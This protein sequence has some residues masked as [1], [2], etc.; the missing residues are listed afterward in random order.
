MGKVIFSGVGKTR[1]E[2]RQALDAG[3]GC[4]NVESEPELERLSDIAQ[5]LGKVAPVSVRINPDVDAGT[6]AKISTGKAENK[7]GVPY[8]RAAGMFARLAARS[9]TL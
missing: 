4:F 8:D 7:F 6:H 5:S 1:A 2:M 3:I 9:L